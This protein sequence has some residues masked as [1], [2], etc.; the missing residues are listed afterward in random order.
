M[1]R[2]HERYSED[3]A[4]FVL[5]ALA[6]LEAEALEKHLRSCDDCRREV[7]ELRTGAEALARSVDQIE[8]SARL[9]TRLLE[10]MG[11]EPTVADAAAAAVVPETSP[12]RDATRSRSALG[13]TARGALARLRPSR[14][15]RRSAGGSLVPRP[16]L[17]LAAG[18][19]AL[20]AGVGGW[21]IGTAGGTEGDRTVTASVD[22]DRLPEASGKLSITA[23]GSEPVLRL[24][25]LRNL[26]PQR[27]Y[28]IWVQ[29]DG[30][31]SPGPLFSPT[32]DGAAVTGI[33]GGEGDIEA[34]FVTR[35]PA[36]GARTPSETPIVSAPVS[37]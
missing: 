31:L 8:P 20:V 32:A 15:G 36:G 12:A 16:A 7:V 17:V 5:G 3:V 29:R 1:A 33:L 21:A 22:R 37:L 25:G 30:E 10:K 26:G 34:V 4:P 13:A 9:R 2:D 24:A 28:E 14:A 35:E 23:D 11:G 27:T 6:P 19:V 18:L